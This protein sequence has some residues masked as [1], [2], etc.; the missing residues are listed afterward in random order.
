M[1]Q[2][3]I[4]FNNT[5]SWT[6]DGLSNDRLETF[7]DLLRWCGANSLLDAAEVRTLEERAGSDPW[8][9]ATVLGQA[10][11]LRSVLHRIL[12]A[13]AGEREPEPVAL[14]TFNQ[15]LRS[16]AGQLALTWREGRPSWELQG[17]ATPDTIVDRIAWAAAQFI[18]SPELARLGLCANP[19]CGWMFLD[20]T[21]NHSRRWCSM[22]DCGSR[23]KARRYYRRRKEKSGGESRA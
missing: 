4:S 17:G 2:A 16:A 13:L 20:S 7:P 1:D 8:L 9:A 22:Q 3:A 12:A 10:R 11:E 18:T 6:G 19:E 23:A 15:A 21:R 14:R 5:A